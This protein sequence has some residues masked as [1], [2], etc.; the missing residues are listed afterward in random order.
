MNVTGKLGRCNLSTSTT[1]QKDES[2]NAIINILKRCSDKKTDGVIKSPAFLFST[3]IWSHLAHYWFSLN[4]M[5]KAKYKTM[6][7]W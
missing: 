7:T 2:S 4:Y 1:I 3:K 6:E 5:C